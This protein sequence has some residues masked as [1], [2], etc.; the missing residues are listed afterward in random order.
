MNQQTTSPHENPK[1]G[2]FAP[3]PSGDMHIGNLR[4][5]LLA[6]IWARQTG[7]RF[8]LRIEDIDRVKPGAAQRQIEDLAALGLTWDEPPLYQS[9][10]HD[11]HL[12]AIETLAQRDLLFE[13]YCTR[14]EIAEAASAPHGHPGHYPGTCA[15]LTDKQRTQKRAELAALNRAPAL[16]LRPTV[17]EWTIHDELYGT[18]TEPID[19]VVLQRG[20]G[21]LAYNLAVVVDDAWQN[22][23]QIVRADDLLSSAPAQSYIA[24]ELGYPPFTYAHVPLVLSP[25]GARLA[26]R[27][28]AVTLRD[29]Q[30]H[31]WSVT[32]LI[33]E[34]S[35]SLGF[36]AT[37]ASELLTEFNPTKMQR[38]PWTFTPPEK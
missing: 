24:H 19:Q 20:D 4:T 18:V 5:A 30:T 11:A 35:T 25:T 13:C 21:T 8:V 22:V 32:R 15:N 2:R 1:A 16:R 6:W 12:K 38:T 27:D 3:S 10:R 28:G 23:D 31:G 33:R 17:N 34:I 14:R 7:R 29:L 36:D 37:T 9:T 26:K